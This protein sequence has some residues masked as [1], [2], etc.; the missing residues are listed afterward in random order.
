MNCPRCDHPRQ[1]E[2]R[3]CPRCGIDY[4]YVESKMAQTPSDTR[5][6]AEDPERGKTGRASLAPIQADPR[7]A[8]S[9]GDA[10]GRGQGAGKAPKACPKCG[11]KNDAALSECLRCGVIFAKYETYLEKKRRAEEEASKT[12]DGLLDSDTLKAVLEGTPQGAP[13]PAEIKTACPHCGQHYKIR[14]DQIGITT[15]CRKCSSI[16][17]IEG[18]LEND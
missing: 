2:D 12:T 5:P 11:F 15:R 9:P 3:E 18:L 17:T 8:P 13:P 4:A 16:F 6:Q 10:A 7:N 14:D 1:P